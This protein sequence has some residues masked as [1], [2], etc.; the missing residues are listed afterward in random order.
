M[1]VRPHPFSCVFELPEI[2]ENHHK[3]IY[4]MKVQGEIYDRRICNDAGYHKRA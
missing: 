4:E 3:V 1:G 2:V